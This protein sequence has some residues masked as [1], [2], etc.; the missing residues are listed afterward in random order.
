LGYYK[1]KPIATGFMQQFKSNWALI[2]E[3]NLRFVNRSKYFVWKK[4]KL[5]DKSFTDGY[6][7][8]VCFFGAGFAVFGLLFFAGADLLVFG[9]RFFAGVGFTFLGLRFFTGTLGLARPMTATLR[10]SAQ[11]RC[12]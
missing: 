7:G 9:L 6:S 11:T 2:V 1:E 12:R 10:S 8:L 4:L 5:S 3:R